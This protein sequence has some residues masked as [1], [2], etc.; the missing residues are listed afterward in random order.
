MAFINSGQLCLAIKRLYVHESIYDKFLDALVKFTQQLKVGNGNEEGVFFGPV[1]N[2]AQFEKV[3]SFFTDIERENL[4]IALGGHKEPEKGYFIT[5]TII[6]R[7][8]DTARIATQE[9][10]GESD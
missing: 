3:K 7:P 10:F 6:D 4:K 9:V 2:A 5:P 8:A 1:Q